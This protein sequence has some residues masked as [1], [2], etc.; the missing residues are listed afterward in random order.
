MSSCYLSHY[1]A[2]HLVCVFLW[3]IWKHV[4]PCSICS[5][6][7]PCEQCA[8]TPDVH[9]AHREYSKSNTAVQFVRSCS[10]TVSRLMSERT[11]TRVRVAVCHLDIAAVKITIPAQGVEQG[12]DGNVPWCNLS[13]FIGKVVMRLIEHCRES[14]VAGGLGAE[15]CLAWRV[16]L[17]GWIT[18]F[19]WHIAFPLNRTKNSTGNSTHRTVDV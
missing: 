9:N 12:R 15:L 5:L 2:W 16:F 14:S 4:G 7:L 19:H 18:L 6:C 3:I 11:Q 13:V 17:A 8:F 1:T 10:Y